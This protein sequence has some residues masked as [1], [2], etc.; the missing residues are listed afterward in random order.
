MSNFSTIQFDREYGT[1]QYDTDS[2]LVTS[3][4]AATWADFETDLDT[5]VEQQ[6]GLSGYVLSP[7]LVTIS[8]LGFKTDLELADVRTLNEQRVN[9]VVERSRLIPEATI[10]LGSLA[11]RESTAR[12][13][14]VSRFVHDGT[15]VGG[16]HKQTVL[17]L[18]E[19]EIFASATEPYAVTQ[20]SSDVKLGICADLLDYYVLSPDTKTL[21]ISGFW[22]ISTGRNIIEVPEIERGN[23]EMLHSRVDT[24][25]AYNVGLTTIAMCDRALPSAP[26]GGPF[27]FIARR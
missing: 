15:I 2:G 10:L 24:V 1:N 21:L 20:P 5:L 11:Y 3:L 18:A 8:D 7:E 22:G 4:S 26:T 27:N 12:P 14:N 9:D 6:P 25:F 19:A 13:Y 16:T 17:G 23:L